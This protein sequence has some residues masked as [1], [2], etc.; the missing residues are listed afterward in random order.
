MKRVRWTKDARADLA[1]ADAYYR[2]LNPDF[3]YRIGQSAIAAGRFLAE[4]PRAGPVFGGG[5]RKWRIANTDYLL[6]Y[7]LVDGGVEIVRLRHAYE[8]WRTDR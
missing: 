6:I 2:P 5:A 7:R 8:N 4:H 3:S 1:A